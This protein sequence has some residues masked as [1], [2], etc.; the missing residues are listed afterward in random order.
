MAL[1][2]QM[3]DISLT[4]GVDTKMVQNT[5]LDTQFTEIVNMRSD[6][7][8]GF[9][10]RSGYSVSSA[11]SASY[12]VVA[13]TWMVSNPTST[14]YSATGF[15]RGGYIGSNILT[16]PA[17]VK[18][19]AFG[20]R[21]DVDPQYLAVN[22]IGG[23]VLLV[24]SYSGTTRIE[25][26]W[27]DPSTDSMEQGGYIPT[28]NA[29]TD[30]QVTS[31][32]DY[33]R[34]W[35]T[36]GTTSIFIYTV[37]NSDSSPVALTFGAF[38]AVVARLDA[39]YDSIGDKYY[40]LYVEGTNT[41]LAQVTIVGS[42][43]T[44]GTPVTLIAAASAN[45]ALVTA[46]G[47]GATTYV[48]IAAYVTATTTFYGGCYTRANPPVLVGSLNTAAGLPA[49]VNN[50][51]ICDA[52]TATIA[53]ATFNT[54]NATTGMP[55]TRQ[56]LITTGSMIVSAAI[57]T[58]YAVYTG[59]I[60]LA[61]QNTYS[62]FAGRVDIQNA[63]TYSSAGLGALSSMSYRWSVASAAIQLVQRGPR[64]IEVSGRYIVPQLWEGRVESITPATSG[65]DTYN[66]QRNCGVVVIDTNK[67][68]GAQYFAYGTA[69]VVAAGSLYG[70]DSQGLA[71]QCAWPIPVIQVSTLATAAGGSLDANSRYSYRIAKRWTDSLGNILESI[72][73]PFVIS[74]AGANQ[75]ITFV[76]PGNT[77]PLSQAQNSGAAAVKFYIYRTEGNGTIHYLRSS[78]T[79]QLSASITITDT[80]ADSSLDLSDSLPYDGGELEDIEVAHIQH[81][82]LWQGRL[83][84]LTADYNNKVY[85]SKPQE[86]FRQVRFASGLEISFPAA[87]GGLTA[88]AGMD[89]SLYAFSRNQIFTVSGQP[90]GATGEN[91][92]IGSPELRFS[93]I[94]CVA[95]KSVV[96]TPKGIA[97]QSDKGIYLIL[98]NQELTFIG[99]G[100][101]ADR[102]TTIMGAYADEARSEIHYTLS[103]GVVWVYNWQENLWTSFQLASTPLAASL[104]G[105]TAGY[106]STGGV[107]QISAS[108]TEVIPLTM[109]SAWI[110]TTGI[111]GFQR[112]RNIML[113][114]KYLAAHTLTISI[115]T[116]Y[117]NDTAV[118]TYTINTATDVATTTPYQLRLHLQNQKCEAVKIKITSATAGWEISG[119][120]MEVGVKRDHYKARTAPNTF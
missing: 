26:Q 109:T 112:V 117:N 1:D 119:L 55:E 98:R 34:V 16:A 66:T 93:G 24:W 114:L 52:K 43:V 4:Q 50:L 75:T 64:I 56:A 101:F 107:N 42:G 38:G 13:P 14:L 37:F 41:K 31:G 110:A 115:Y 97:F 44:L 20:S 5:T 76:I 77:T 96:I 103:T 68:V 61:A 70:W 108:S 19:R 11:S 118:Q 59:P 8:G 25:Y 116:D 99:G 6:Y 39:Y 88:I 58:P 72:S 82:T 62:V 83:V 47:S 18:R 89:Y 102:A 67:S 80:T 69:Q 60:A 120:S 29:V 3:I 17:E 91:G 23:K 57:N 12:P 84:A 51:G 10:P 22:A 85:Y 21:L 87:S 45:V 105:Q 113:L 54:P 78:H 106:L 40:L 28:S 94:G 49:T 15:V 53:T 65:F 95:A 79:P 111:Q 100:P 2:T 92:S 104:Q 73:P 71:P 35:F 7:T 30:M 86:D 90:A 74:T 36:D 9:A 48:C 33:A 46:A 81:M 63:A 27:Y 32:S